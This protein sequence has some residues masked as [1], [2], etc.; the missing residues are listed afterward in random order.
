MDYDSPPRPLK[1]TRRSTRRKAFVKK[2]EGTVL[3]EILIDSQAGSSG[4]A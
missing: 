1:Q 3:V 4:R 2:I